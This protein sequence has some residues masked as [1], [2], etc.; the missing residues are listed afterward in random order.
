MRKNWYILFFLSF[1]LF[2]KIG[3]SVDFCFLPDKNEYEDLFIPRLLVYPTK[4]YPVIFILSKKSKNIDSIVSFL[5]SRT[6]QWVFPSTESK[7]KHFLSGRGDD[8]FAY[9]GDLP[10]YFYSFDKDRTSEFKQLFISLKIKKSKLNGAVYSLNK[11]LSRWKK[12]NRSDTFW[13][14]DKL[15]SDFHSSKVS[16][17]RFLYMFLPIMDKLK[18]TTT[19][20][21]KLTFFKDSF[22]EKN[23]KIQMPDPVKVKQERERFNSEIT[24]LVSKLDSDDMLFFSKNVIPNNL[25][26]LSYQKFMLLMAKL[27]ISVKNE[28]PE[29]LRYLYYCAW[30]KEMKK[31]SFFVEIN[32]AIN[33]V[34]LKL[35]SDENPLISDWIV[36]VDTLSKFLS[37]EI[38]YSDYK[39]LTRT[40]L[41]FKSQGEDRSVL[42]KISVVWTDFERK[43]LSDALRVFDKYVNFSYADESNLKESIEKNDSNAVILVGDEI[44]VQPWLYWF[45]K[46]T[47]GAVFKMMPIEQEDEGETRYFELMRGE[48]SQFEKLL[49]GMGDD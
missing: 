22:L 29:Y 26:L 47:S 6:P 18:I 24:G 38:T 14:F 23:V 16:P 49:N 4:S 33:K 7:A 2:A 15:V 31:E 25:D 28:Y 30:R 10:K 36:F 27:G 19:A 11:I 45:S 46:K 43:K 48:K 42:D 37:S 21:S 41:S 1:F 20:Y 8:D 40:V 5:V 13:E 9:M 44:D 35:S 32:D 12:D 39:T 17:E 34:R 3:Y